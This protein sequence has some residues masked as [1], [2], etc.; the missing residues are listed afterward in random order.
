MRALRYLLLLVP[1]ACQTVAEPQPASH[2]AASNGAAAPAAREVAA[3]ARVAAPVAA[4][5]A[6]PLFPPAKRNIKLRFV[7]GGGLPLEDVLTE[8]RAATGANFIVSSET[9]TI[10][11]NTGSGLQQELEIPATSAW[12]VVEALLALHELMLVPARRSEPCLVTV[13]A[14]AP[15]ARGGGGTLKGHAITV[16]SADL[17]RYAEHVAVL[18]TTVLDVDPLDARQVSTSLRQMFPDQQTQSVLPVSSTSLLLTGFAGDVA[19]M[20]RVL[21]E[22]AAFERERIANAPPPAASTET[23]ASRTSP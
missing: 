1:V 17:P 7:E 21:Q 10:L 15:G 3:P 12:P 2:G 13:Y 5:D 8:L 18:V 4:P 16:A 11:A 20:A 22:C 19:A 23:A 14:V 9:R 6:A